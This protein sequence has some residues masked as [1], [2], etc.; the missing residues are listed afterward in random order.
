MIEFYHLEKM[1]GRYI[2]AE[3]LGTLRSTEYVL[4]AL[5][6]SVAIQAMVVFLCATL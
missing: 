5:N 2:E 3:L 1:I 4:H 6:C